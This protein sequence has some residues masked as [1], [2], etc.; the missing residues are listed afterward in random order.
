MPQS[1]LVQLSNKQAL[2]LAYQTAEIKV[3][4][5]AQSYRIGS[6]E[7]TRADLREIRA[8]RKKLENEV[9]EIEGAISNGGRRRVFRITPRDL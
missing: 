4:E 7:I 5:G 8:E 6:R 2:L 9:A 3:L 1:L